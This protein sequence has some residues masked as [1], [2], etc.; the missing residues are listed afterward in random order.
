VKD[1]QDLC[2]KT[3]N[4]DIVRCKSPPNE[5]LEMYI[6]VLNR[7]GTMLKPCRKEVLVDQQPIRHRERHCSVC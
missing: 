5:A 2:L 7:V 4:R 1:A 3:E 6:G